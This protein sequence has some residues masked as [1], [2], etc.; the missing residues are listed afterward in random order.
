MFGHLYVVTGEGPGQR[1]PCRF[2]EVRAVTFDCLEANFANDFQGERAAEA[3]Q[4]LLHAERTGRSRDGAFIRFQLH[5]VIA[6]LDLMLA[7]PA[8]PMEE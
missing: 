2:G 7:T 5:Q 4:A 1:I 6:V 3:V 8:T